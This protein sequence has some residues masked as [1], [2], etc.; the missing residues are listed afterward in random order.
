M[1]PHA[2]K[3]V[4]GSSGVRKLRW[5]ISGQGKSG[6]I[7]VLYYWRRSDDE[8]WLLTAY[9][10]S[11]RDTIPSHILKKIAEEIKDD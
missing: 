6:G 11:E 4:R 9:G 1:H 3:I 2:G 7:R 5:A 8:I 10:K